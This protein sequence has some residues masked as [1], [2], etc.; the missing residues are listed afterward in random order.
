MSGS[1]FVGFAAA[2][3]DTG[4]NVYNYEWMASI[5]LIFAALFVFP[6]YL[7]SKVY[8]MPEFWNAGSIGGPGTRSAGSRS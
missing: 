6:I 7:R 3:Y 4:V 5:V 1:S 8:T 2:G